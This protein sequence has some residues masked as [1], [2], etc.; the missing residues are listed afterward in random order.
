MPIEPHENVRFGH[1]ILLATGS[2]HIRI[3]P[4]H[5]LHKNIV[6]NNRGGLHKI[7]RSQ[8][9]FDPNPH[10]F[11][12]AIIQLQSEPHPPDPDHPL[13]KPH[14]IVLHLTTLTR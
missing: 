2:A 11:P 4:E 1:K 12:V 5:H 8:T 10:L 7:M 6:A 9:A 13:A 3:P 14:K